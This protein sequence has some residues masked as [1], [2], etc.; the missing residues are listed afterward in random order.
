MTKGAE[1][2][3]VE[4]SGGDYEESVYPNSGFE[5]NRG[6]R[7]HP[8]VVSNKEDPGIYFTSDD[9]LSDEQDTRGMDIEVTSQND[10]FD[11]T[12]L[13]PAPVSFLD[14]CVSMYIVILIVSLQF[15]VLTIVPVSVTCCILRQRR[16]STLSNSRGKSTSNRSI[17]RSNLGALE[18]S[19][20]CNYYGSSPVG[21]LEGSN[22]FEY[23]TMMAY[24]RRE[25]QSNY[26]NTTRS[27]QS[28]S[29]RPS[30]V[31]SQ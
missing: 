16:S 27:N 9:N 15:V 19:S 6:T 10:T 18:K 26:G 7:R 30:Y 20:E 24:A 17:S 31:Y 11:F 29:R 13:G 1:I 22:C 28:G 3:R 5:T 21:T 8:D 23:P 14:T 4:G 2:S 12:P 25:S